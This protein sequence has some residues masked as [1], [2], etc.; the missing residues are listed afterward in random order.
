MLWG[1]KQ[2]GNVKSFL[3]FERR[4][5]AEAGSYGHCQHSAAEDR[6]GSQLTRTEQPVESLAV[7]AEPGASHGVPREGKAEHGL[8]HNSGK[9]TK[10]REEKKSQ[11]SNSC[12]QLQNKWHLL[13]PLIPFDGK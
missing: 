5:H 1:K 2:K 13:T 3:Y 4:A 8:S 10:G 7:S 11:T 6:Q 12:S 9:H